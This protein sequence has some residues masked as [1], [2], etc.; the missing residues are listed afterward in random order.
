MSQP[1]FGHFFVHMS[2]L[3]VS[4]Q[5]GLS[6]SRP[7]APYRARALMRLLPEPPLACTHAALPP[8]VA[9]HDYLLYIHHHITENVTLPTP[10]LTAERNGVGYRPCP[11]CVTML[12]LVHEHLYWAKIHL[13]QLRWGPRHCA[14][15]QTSSLSSALFFP[16]P[17]S[18][19][20]W[21]QAAPPFFFFHQ[22]CRNFDSL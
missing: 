9:E 4:R 8:A 19:D 21:L 1:V 16:I 17:V 13:F 18:F 12:I 2:V 10:Q 6:N 22:H 5:S 20:S 7:V 11:R 3:T 14:L 15:S